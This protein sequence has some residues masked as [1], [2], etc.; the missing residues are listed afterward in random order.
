[1]IMVTRTTTHES[2]LARPVAADDI[3][4]GD[5]VAVL[6][7][8][9]EFPSFLWPCDSEL[10][11]IH[12]PVRMQWRTADGGQPLKVIDFC[13]PFVLVKCPSGRH[14]SLDMRSVQLVKLSQDYARRAWK[15]L[16]KSEKPLL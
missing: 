4:R 9:H 14:Q 11:P 3:R 1:M 5:F 13:L 10:T 8:I 6:N 15:R 12:Q 7:E 2:T 16:K